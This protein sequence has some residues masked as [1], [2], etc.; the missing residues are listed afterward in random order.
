MEELVI[1]LS[2]D[3]EI[4][5]KDMDRLEKG[6]F[7]KKVDNKIYYFPKAQKILYEEG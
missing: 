5:I 3:K 1:D 7:V 4:S 2:K 6:N